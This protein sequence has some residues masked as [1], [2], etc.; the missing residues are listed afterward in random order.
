MNH[1][2]DTFDEHAVEAF[3]HTVMFGH[4]M[5]GDSAFCTFRFKMLTEFVTQVLP[6]A[7]RAQT[8]YFGVELGG[9]PSLVGFVGR[10]CFGLRLL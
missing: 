10:K 7:I 9:Q 6:A 5:D 1:H 4:V 3:S 8:L 2:T